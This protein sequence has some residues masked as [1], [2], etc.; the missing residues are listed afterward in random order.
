MTEA[1][2]EM[3]CPQAKEIPGL[4]EMTGS[5]EKAMRQ[6]LCRNLQEE[7]GSAGKFISDFQALEPQ[8]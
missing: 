2:V 7:D 1:E 3:M 4:P 5:Y 8:Q 6:I